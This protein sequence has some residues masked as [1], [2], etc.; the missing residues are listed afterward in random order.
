MPGQHI[1]RFLFQTALPSGA[2][3][4]FCDKADLEAS[5]RPPALLATKRGL[6]VVE[7]PVG[8]V[9]DGTGVAGF[10]PTLGLLALEVAFDARKVLLTDTDLKVAGFLVEDV[11]EWPLSSFFF[12]VSVS[13]PPLMLTSAEFT[14][15]STMSLTSLSTIEVDDSPFTSASGPARA[16]LLRFVEASRLPS[17]VCVAGKQVRLRHVEQ[18]EDTTAT[19]LASA[20][21]QKN[22]AWET[23]RAKQQEPRVLRRT[24]LAWVPPPSSDQ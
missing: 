13:E 15:S 19:Q 1:R 8:V 24:G 20:K 16:S 4:P 6:G 11:L 23:L 22:Q 5:R 7:V 9:V 18:I 17:S 2:G 12:E 10:S 14:T 3:R 21:K